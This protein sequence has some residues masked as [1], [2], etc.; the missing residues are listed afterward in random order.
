VADHH[1]RGAA[2]GSVTMSN[3]IPACPRK[4]VGRARVSY[5]KTLFVEVDCGEELLRAPRG[6][7]P[8]KEGE[9]GKEKAR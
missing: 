6:P 7:T 3:C 9:S 2:R 1:S 4:G 8:P 5:Y